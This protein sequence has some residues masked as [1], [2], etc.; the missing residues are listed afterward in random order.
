VLRRALLTSA[1][2][3]LVLF[4]V[5]FHNSMRYALHLNMGV[6]SLDK[7]I[8]WTDLSANQQKEC[9]QKAIN[10]LEQ[11]LNWRETCIGRR[12]LG[13]AYEASG[14]LKQAVSQ[15]RAGG[16]RVEDFIILG[17]QARQAKRYEEALRRYEWAAEAAPGSGDPWYYK[18]L[19]YDGMER[20]QDALRMYERAIGTGSLIGV[21]RGSPYYRIGVIYHRRV[22][23]S[24]LQDALIAYE[25]ALRVDDF[26]TTAEAADCH[27]RCGEILR[28]QGAPADKYI[29]HYQQA[30]AMNPK[31]ALAGIWLG[32]SYY[33]Q[34]KDMEMAE[35]E[36]RRIL[37]LDSENALAYVHLGDLY[38]QE[39][40]IN[41][42]VAMYR[43]ALEI[44]PESDAAYKRLLWLSEGE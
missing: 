18:G 34:Y 12:Q 42:A 6:V 37:E 38:H 43:R 35:S 22:Y 28:W 24:Q 41:E 13:R 31:H 1:V 40:R 3:L 9:L 30:V 36:I 14:D 2:V 19:A 21:G 8:L 23:P 11:A 15:W 39:E 4:R 7:A 33:I 17:D 27:Y 20:W 5:R 32:T 29:A 26:G 10:H 16:L 44:K 25:T